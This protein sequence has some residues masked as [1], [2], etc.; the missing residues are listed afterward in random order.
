MNV[1]FIAS[2]DNCARPSRQHFRTVVQGALERCALFLEQSFGRCPDGFEQ[3]GR[4][5]QTREGDVVGAGRQE[6]VGLGQDF[7]GRDDLRFGFNP[8]S[9]RTSRSL[10]VPFKIESGIV[11]MRTSACSTSA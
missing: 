11:Q 1:P 10:V 2:R 5:V 4:L 3:V 8:R 6:R 7:G 9:I